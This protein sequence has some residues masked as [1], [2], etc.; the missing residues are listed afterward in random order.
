MST[1]QNSVSSDMRIMGLNVI[2]FPSA[3]TPNLQW[4]DTIKSFKWVASSSNIMSN[5]KISRD[6]YWNSA[7]ASGQV[8][9]EGDVNST[10]KGLF[11]DN[12]GVN[13][14]KSV[15]LDD[16]ASTP[17]KA[18]AFGALVI[19]SMDVVGNPVTLVEVWS[20]DTLNT[21]DGTQILSIP[22]LVINKKYT[23]VLKIGSN[24]YCTVKCTT[25][26]LNWGGNNSA[27]LNLGA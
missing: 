23:F 3:L 12:P 1:I 27:T 19:L 14:T 11:F 17:F 5:K 18:G 16:G 7:T 13:P 20:S 26:G 6:N 15:I 24:Q 2:G 25:A 9:I 4:D 21:A 8:T 10:Y 22:A